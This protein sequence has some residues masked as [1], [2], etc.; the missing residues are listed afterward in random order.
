MHCFK[1]GFLPPF[2]SEIFSVLRIYFS[3]LKNKIFLHK[4]R[5]FS[6]NKVSFQIYHMMNLV[7]SKI[8][9]NDKLSVVIYRLI[10]VLYFL[11]RITF[12]FSL[13]RNTVL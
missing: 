4:V 12:V 9:K 11:N 10:H 1:K 3:F 7:E 8:S 5:V 13:A 2:N 6:R